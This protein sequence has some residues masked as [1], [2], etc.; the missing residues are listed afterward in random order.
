[1]KPVE[2]VLWHRVRGGQWR[3]IE[4]SASERELTPLL[5]K[6][7]SGD[8]VCFRTNHVAQ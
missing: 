2:I 6:L 4:T 5:A 3:E 8:S 1:M 7:P